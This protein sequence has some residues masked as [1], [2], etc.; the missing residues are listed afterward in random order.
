MKN[1]FVFFVIQLVFLNKLVCI[2]FQEVKLIDLKKIYDIYL[3]L[4]YLNQDTMFYYF[5]LNNN[6]FVKYYKLKITD[7]KLPSEII[8]FEDNRIQPFIRKSDNKYNVN[9]VQ[10]KTLTELRQ[11]KESKVGNKE[12][13]FFGIV[14]RYVDL[15]ILFFD[16]YK[17]G[18]WSGGGVIL[19][20]DIECSIQVASKGTD[21][22]I[23][24]S[25]IIKTNRGYVYYSI[26]D[27]ININLSSINNLN[28]MNC[29]IGIA[30]S[31]CKIE[32]KNRPDIIAIF[33]YEDKEFYD[34]IIKA[35]HVN[36]EKGII[37]K[38]ENI[39]QIKCENDGYGL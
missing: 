26:L 1:L 10:Y 36:I 13:P 37:E 23:I 11:S 38:F 2:E 22:V 18:A 16:K 14:Y 5:S 21:N 33:I 27:T 39:K 29:N 24:L 34:N 20:G 32:N 17:T 8:K 9:L 7:L 30:C 15:D 28:K 3:D 6:N 4:R 19:K 12:N 31:G 25:K 35:W